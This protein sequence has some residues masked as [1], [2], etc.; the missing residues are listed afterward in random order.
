VTLRLW[1]T[2]LAP[3]L[4]SF[5]RRVVNDQCSISSGMLLEIL[6]QAHSSSL[7]LFAEG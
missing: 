4:I 7:N 1:R 3:I 5:S 6:L 2:T